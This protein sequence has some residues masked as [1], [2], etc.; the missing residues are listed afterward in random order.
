MFK[1]ENELKKENYLPVSDF[2]HASK[3]F[4]RIVFN[5][6]NLFFESRFWP[7]LA[8]FRKNHSTQNVLLN[9]TEKYKHALDKGKKVGAIFI[10]LSKAFD[11][12]NHDLLL[13]K[14]NAY[15]FSY[16]AIKFIQSYF[17]E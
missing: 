9:M 15:G 7:L 16:Y 17:S 1:K 11:T 8:G 14:L 4:E 13:P 3:I 5:Q 12:L 10:H 6:I 2:S